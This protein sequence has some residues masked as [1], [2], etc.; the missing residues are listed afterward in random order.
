MLIKGN[1][2]VN[3]LGSKTI[4]YGNIHVTTVMTR[5]MSVKSQFKSINSK[6]N[7]IGQEDSQE[8]KTVLSAVRKAGAL[9]IVLVLASLMW[10]STMSAPVPS[11]EPVVDIE[12]DVRLQ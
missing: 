12:Q 6:I 4:K 9:S 7:R 8:S 5:Q 11:P 10:N 3:I 1:K 2:M